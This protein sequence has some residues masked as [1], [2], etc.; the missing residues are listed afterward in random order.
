MSVAP[1][2]PKR[3]CLAKVEIVNSFENWK[4]NLV[5]T[6][7][8]DPNFAPFLTDD[9]K[10]EKKTKVAPLR[11]F[12]DDADGTPGKSTAQQKVTMLELMLGQIANFC[13]IISLKERAKRDKPSKNQNIFYCR[14]RQ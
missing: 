2:A 11:G 1:R 5:Y 4:Q 6:L 12:V 7:S 14:I 13:P 10:W 3:W 9:A 8:L